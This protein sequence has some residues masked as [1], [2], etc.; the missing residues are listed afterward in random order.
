M[1]FEVSIWKYQSGEE[2]EGDDEGCSL[3]D[4]WE[5]RTCIQIPWWGKCYS[6]CLFAPRSRNSLQ[7]SLKPVIKTTL[8]FSTQK[9]IE[10]LCKHHKTLPHL[11]SEVENY[12]PHFSQER[13]RERLRQTPK[14]HR[15]SVTEVGT[16]ISY[17]LLFTD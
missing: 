3:S 1:D 10:P 5:S 17:E 11:A 6:H 15:E 12:Y 4:V 2:Q 9:F 14:S 16:E 13:C 7:Y 8:S